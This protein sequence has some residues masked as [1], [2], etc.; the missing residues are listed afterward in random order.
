MNRRGRNA[1]VA[2]GGVLAA[3][4]VVASRAAAEGQGLQPQKHGGVG[5]RGV[6]GKLRQE[7]IHQ[8]RDVISSF[9]KGGQV[10]GENF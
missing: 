6:R 4:L 1:Y 3:A 7:M 10:N 5:L 2:L 9:D 8:Q